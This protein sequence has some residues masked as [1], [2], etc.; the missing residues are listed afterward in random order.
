MT[1]QELEVQIR[2]SLAQI[3]EQDVSDVPS[4]VDLTKHLG[5]DSLSRLEL[6]S[7]V[8][9]RLDVI[10]YDIDTEKASTIRGMVEICEGALQESEEAA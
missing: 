2:K 7:E 1:K 8:E 5:L 3:V 9:E 10:I 4:N 6:L